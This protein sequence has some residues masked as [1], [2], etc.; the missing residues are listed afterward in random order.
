MERRHI[1]RRMYNSFRDGTKAQTE[2]TALANAAGLIP[3]I[4]GMHEPSLNLEDIP[5][6][7]SLETEGGLLSQHGVVELANSVAFAHKARLKKDV[8]ARSPISYGNVDLDQTTALYR[9]R[10]E[11]DKA[12]WNG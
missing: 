6:A 7:F 4:C 10:Q 11:Q 3:D 8:A 12:V 5:Q 2:M 1:N 9:V